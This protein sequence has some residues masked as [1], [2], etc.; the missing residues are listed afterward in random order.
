MRRRLG[1]RNSEYASGEHHF[2]IDIPIGLW[3]IASRFLGR[4]SYFYPEGITPAISSVTVV[5][6]YMLECLVD[7][8][9]MPL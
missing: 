4:F 3:C 8:Y 2:A 1:T 9:L 6:L 7:A 5:E